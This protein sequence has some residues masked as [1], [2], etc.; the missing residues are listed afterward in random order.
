VIGLKK[1]FPRLPI[2]VIASRGE[3][4]QGFPRVT[5]RGVALFLFRQE[6]LQKKPNQG[7]DFDPRPLNI[8]ARTT[9]GG[10]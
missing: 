7:A 10:L 3:A 9:K 1:V 5:A 2:I 4:I 6:K 8:P